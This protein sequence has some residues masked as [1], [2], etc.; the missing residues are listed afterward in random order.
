MDKKKAD[1]LMIP[2][3]KKVKGIVDAVPFSSQDGR[4]ILDIEQDAE[5]RSLM[6]LGKV[7]NAGV[8]DVLNCDLIYAVLNNM[9][10]DW[11]SCAT[12]ILKKDDEVV[13]EEV[14]DEKVIA[15]LSKRKDVWFMHKNFVVYKDK[16]SF[17][18][19][20]MRKI[21]YFEIPRLPAEWYLAEDNTFQCHSIIYASP[22]TPSDTFLKEQ[23]FN[24]SDEKGLG[25]ILVGV[26]L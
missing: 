24:E 1:A 8:R 26:K 14:R 10:F 17:P 23:H 15:K 20:I 22:C 19:D 11:G 12:L 6:G 5:K 4:K 2:I 7:F 16:I 13:G 9:D 21:C 3:L 18:Q 25:T